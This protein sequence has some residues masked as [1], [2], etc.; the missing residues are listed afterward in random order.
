MKNLPKSKL[1]KHQVKTIHKQINYDGTRCDLVIS[2]RYDDECGNNHNTFAITGDIYKRG[3]RSDRAYLAGGCV[4]AEIAKHATLAP[5]IKWHLCS[6]NGPLHYVANTLYHISD[7]DC[8]GLKQGE[9]QSFTYKVMV[10]DKCL[11]TSRI[12]YSFRNWI[13]RDE[14]KE[15]ATTFLKDIKPQLLPKIV[16]CGDGAA[17]KGKPRDLDA[18]RSTAIWPDATLEDLTEENLKARLPA[19][20]QDFKTT[21]ESLGFIY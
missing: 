3:Q 1:V 19:L 15:Q 6:S 13:H 20:M 5:L 2:I 14:A 17:S 18:A 8:N 21:I 10:K 12:F 9:Y 16:Q 4:H 7:K 11:Y